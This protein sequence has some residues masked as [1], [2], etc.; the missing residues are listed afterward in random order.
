[1]KKY[2][3]KK[4]R[5]KR[6]SQLH[7]WFVLLLHAVLPWIWSSCSMKYPMVELMPPKLIWLISSDPMDTTLK[8]TVKDSECL[9]RKSLVL[10]LTMP[11]Q[12]KLT[13]RKSTKWHSKLSKKCCHLRDLRIVPQ[14]LKKTP[15]R[16]LR[17]T[18]YLLS[19]NK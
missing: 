15:T 12:T 7:F 6:L 2:W 10:S 8:Q 4:K 5:W 11:T 13:L 14:L 1:L 18:I 3:K 16:T 9:F 17:D 19:L